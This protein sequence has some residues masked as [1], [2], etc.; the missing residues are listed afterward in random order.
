MPGTNNFIVSPVCPHN[1]NV[2]PLIIPDYC[3]LGL[4]V[5]GRSKNYL[6]SLDSRSVKVEDTTHFELRKCSFSA[7]MVTLPRTNFFDT[8]RQKMS[9]GLDTRN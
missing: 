1:L 5:E 4:Q 7:R 6:A 8:L 9:W 2:R 3:T